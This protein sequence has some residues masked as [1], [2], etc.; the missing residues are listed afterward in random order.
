MGEP[1]KAKVAFN[2]ALDCLD[3]SSLDSPKKEEW[4][5]NINASL[6][7]VTSSSGKT[8]PKE[9]D[10]DTSKSETK[11]PPLL[12]G[13]SRQFPTASSAIYVDADDKS[14]RFFKAKEDIK[15]GETLVAEKPY[16]ACLL[17]DKFGTHCH[18]C[19]VR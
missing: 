19:F 3:S 1:L 2:I 18:H 7:K 13:S 4:R 10:N 17:T 8:G 16:A 6:T 5:K 15:P 9:K 11:F 14:G 12:G